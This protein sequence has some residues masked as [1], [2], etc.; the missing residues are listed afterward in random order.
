VLTVPFV[1]SAMEVRS[2][3]ISYVLV[4]ALLLMSTPVAPVV[5]QASSWYLRRQA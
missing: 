2:Y 5:G 1:P 3:V 4:V